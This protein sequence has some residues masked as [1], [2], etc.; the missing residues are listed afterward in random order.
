M[1][2]LRK[3]LRARGNRWARRRHGSQL[4]PV[5]L[6]RNRIYIL[7]TKAGI[8]FCLMLF[9]IL[10]GSMNYNNSMGLAL[11]FTL[12]SFVLICMHHC[13]RNLL[14]LQVRYGDAEPVF[15]GQN[16][17]IPVTLIN[18]RG[19][20][21]LDLKLGLDGETI[22]AI[23]LQGQ[24]SQTFYLTYTTR[25]RGRF[26]MERLQISCR[27]PCGLFQAWTWIYWDTAVLVYPAPAGRTQL[28]QYSGGI[29]AGRTAIIHGDDEMAELRE[30]Q[31]GD[32]LSRV[33]WKNLARSD[34]MNTKTFNAL[35]EEDLWIEW[36]GSDLTGTEERLS[37]LTQWVVAA[38]QQGR[39]FGLR[40]PDVE[41]TPD[42]NPVH[43]R[44]CLTALALFP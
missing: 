13:H 20:R 43:V 7:P 25:H 44:R 1:H 12:G 27:Y 4:S 38:R 17:R 5:E 35:A 18:N 24:D 33:A 10:I 42:D 32:N 14:A 19:Y 2:T 39:R 28:P 36:T 9:V 29:A 37:Q 40:L 6:Q 22:D 30:F 3:R 15:A 11:A 16:A 34:T 31:P 26:A 41:I 21:R 8:I 23:D